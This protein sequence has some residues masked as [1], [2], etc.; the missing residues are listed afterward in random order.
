M[1][2]Q[3]IN[4]IVGET[5]QDL[6]DSSNKF[7]VYCDNSLIKYCCSDSSVRQGTVREIYTY[8]TE[9]NGTDIPVNIFSKLERAGHTSS[10]GRCVQCAGW[11]WNGSLLK[12]EF[13]EK[14]IGTAFYDEEKLIEYGKAGAAVP[15]MEGGRNIAGVKVDVRAIKAVLYAVV[16]RWLM[17]GSAVCIA[18]PRD[19]DY[20]E[21]VLGAVKTIY[22]YF[23]VGMR[24]EAGFC[25]YMTRAEIRSREKPR[26]YIAFVPEAEADT[27]TIFL[28]GTTATSAINNILEKKSGLKKLD[29]F[30]EYMCSLNDEHRKAF[31]DS[32]YADIEGKGSLEEIYSLKITKYGNLVEAITMLEAEGSIG[33]LLPLWNS[34]YGDPYKYPPSMRGTIRTRIS[35]QLD[36]E[37]FRTFLQEKLSGCSGVSEIAEAYRDIQKICQDELNAAC[38]EAARELLVDALKK[39]TGESGQSVYEALKKSREEFG[40]LVTDEMLSSAAVD[41]FISELEKIKEEYYR[42]PPSSSKEYA[43]IEGQISELL[44]ECESLYRTEK[45]E[46]FAENIRL[47]LRRLEEDDAAKNL[48]LAEDRKKV[49]EAADY[50]QFAK[51]LRQYINAHPDDSAGI[52]DLKESLAQR[53]AANIWEYKRQFEEETGM[54]LD[55]AGIAGLPELSRQ[56]E[57]DLLSYRNI[58]Y[59]CH[60][61][62]DN[63]ENIL[64]GIAKTEALAG[65][66][67]ANHR[68]EVR[69]LSRYG[70]AS[71]ARDILSLSLNDGCNNDD[72][73]LLYELI[74]EGCFRGRDMCRISEMLGKCGENRFSALFEKILLGKFS[75]CSPE[76]Y[77]LAY[78]SIC[79]NV[80]KVSGKKFE[81]SLEKLEKYFAGLDKKELSEDA[82]EAFR[83]FYSKRKK[84]KNSGIDKKI[85]IPIA[86][87]GLAIIVLLSSTVW[88]TMKKKDLSA[89]LAESQNTISE[90]QLKNGELEAQLAPMAEPEVPENSV[91]EEKG[92]DFYLALFEKILNAPENE[93]WLKTA[94]ADYRDGLKDYYGSVEG[95]AWEAAFF[96]ECVYSADENGIIRSDIDTALVGQS[97]DNAL[98]SFYEAESG[99]QPGDEMG[100]AEAEP[101]TSQAQPVE[102]A[103]R[104]QQIEEGEAPIEPAPGDTGG[105]Q[106][107]QSLY[108]EI[109]A[110]KNDIL[111]IA[112]TGLIGQETGQQ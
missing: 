91:S 28:D 42:N 19:V 60:A 61:G 13:A 17:G 85:I 49:T 105:V 107:A 77:C 22:S 57:E 9:N 24:A 111:E 8:F 47:C 63:A 98:G 90:L 23:P 80:A 7:P 14:I 56:I 26:I 38:A 79:S 65:I 96:W 78:E 109:L 95:V 108:E 39:V 48:V 99:A 18:V 16:V 36:A 86:V 52:S 104:P 12:D 20:S 2:Y 94:Y 43:R 4:T 58:G 11:S 88:L 72:I 110:R 87:A 64:L 106:E 31:I 54:R 76:D 40:P 89:Q 71:W 81:D 66:L 55:L 51:R 29:M 75:D 93:E 25:S 82:R 10:V 46:T 67:S 45:T 69:L 15:L 68:V 102:E 59:E 37:A 103:P 5:Y 32:I 34:F 3:F 1:D 73:E 97:V 27:E 101:G 100:D 21:Y 92:I 41:G 70:D 74:D 84:K 53:R 30:V 35:E 112:K 44:R 6:H 50:F 33:E 83:S 62:R